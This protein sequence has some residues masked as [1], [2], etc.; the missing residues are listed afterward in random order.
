MPRVLTVSRVTVA[1]GREAEYLETIRRLAA[2]A[3]PRGQHLWVFRHPARPGQ[4]LEFS[5]SASE[6][7]HRSRA[8]RV[9]EESKLEARLRSLAT[10]A[11]DAWDLWEEVSLGSLAAGGGAPPS[12]PSD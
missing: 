10:Y 6:M 1:E 5:E 12:A 3:S 4:F 2:I 7:S 11:P 8:S 9:G